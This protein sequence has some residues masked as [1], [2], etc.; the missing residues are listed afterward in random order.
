M[1]SMDTKSTLTPASAFGLRLN[2]D[3]RGICGTSV[4]GWLIACVVTAIFFVSPAVAE[5]FSIKCGPEAG[6]YYY[7]SFDE[8]ARKVILENLS[9]RIQRGIIKNAS[10]DNIIFEIVEMNA[11]K[12]DLVF[13]RR[14]NKLT[15]IGVPGDA[16]RQ[17]REFSCSVTGLRSILDT[18]D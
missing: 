1:V 18:Y 13:D 7:F 17:A 16:S 15:R 8:G 9:G 14:N 10:M 11:P 5:K 4:E 3:A 2:C 6:A 12:V